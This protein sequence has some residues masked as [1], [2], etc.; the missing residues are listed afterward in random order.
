MESIKQQIEHGL[1]EHEHAHTPFEHFVR[2][3]CHPGRLLL[4]PIYKRAERY[5]S[6]EKFD[7]KFL[8]TDIL[9]LIVALGLIASAVGWLVWHNRVENRIFFEAQIAPTEIVSGAPSTL[10]IRYTN[11]TGVEL[12]N[13][14]LNI[15]YPAHFELQEI[16]AGDVA[17][18]GGV[19]ALG[20]IVPDA[21]GS[22]KIRGIMFGDVHGEQVFETKMTFTYN[23]KDK[24]GEKTSRYVFS[25]SSSVLKLSLEIPDRIIASQSFSG[26]IVYQNTG[27]ITLPEIIIEPEWPEGFTP[28][29][30]QKTFEVPAIEAGQE[31]RVKFTGTADSGVENLNLI[32]HPSFVFG[33]DQY[34]QD[35]LS[36]V[37]EI[38]QPQIK[39]SHSVDQSTAKPG[40]SLKAT[41]QYQN[42]GDTPIYNVELSLVSDN[43]FAGE[44]KKITVGDLEAKASGEKKIELPL[45]SSIAQSETSTYEHLNIETRAIASYELEKTT[46]AQ[47]ISIIGV[48]VIAPLTTP[49]TLR[50][51]GRY[52]TDSGDQLGRGP[53]PPLVSETT[54]YWIFWNISG[55]TNEIEN[56]TISGQLPD[57]VSFTGRQTV[58]QG[59]SIKYDPTT[60]TVSWSDSKI[61][62]T[63]AS[64][65]KI[66]GIAF[67]VAIVPTESQIG[68]S[69]PLITNISLSGTDGWTNA[70]VTAKGSSVTTDLPGD[71]LADGLG[72][73][74]F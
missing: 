47:K 32:F 1:A 72:K 34:R 45:R 66:V 73:V 2:L 4:S 13:A 69:P 46:D 31:G 50:S 43:P 29:S 6:W 61:N 19:I 36:E 57:N 54:K 21:V 64:T 28:A 7:I 48:E 12:K 55:T 70:W 42:T 16:S 35:S 63:F 20:N 62:P 74:E 8:L 25:P 40:G 44:A 24:R 58:S 52:T 37:I 38:V 23:E 17:S 60:N 5:S 3:L 56:L 14:Y 9:L 10:V 59:S 53:L 68:T 26:N 51:F 65:S 15:T 27:E 39:I 71:I 33:N 11:G 49:I 67:E 30:G 18:D 41:V 22:V